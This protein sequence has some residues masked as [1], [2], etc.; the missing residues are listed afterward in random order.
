MYK[1][2]NFNA[3]TCVCLLL[4]LDA[5]CYSITFL[6]EKCL[7]I[8]CK[9]ILEVLLEEWM[10]CFPVVLIC[11]ALLSRSR[12]SLRRRRSTPTGTTSNITTVLFC[13]SNVRFLL[14]LSVL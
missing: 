8:A 9:V 13:N 14:L 2:E 11:Y 10:V 1:S 5:K 7:K 4:L 12:R 6:T 3:R